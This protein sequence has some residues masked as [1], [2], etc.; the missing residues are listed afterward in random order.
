MQTDYR[1]Y[2]NVAGWLQIEVLRFT[3]LYA[4]YF[5]KDIDFDSLEIGVHHGKFIIGIE[6]ITP[7]QSRCLAIDLFEEQAKNVD[8][9]GRGNLD[10]FKQHV[11]DY[12]TNPSRVQAI[13]A[14]S[15][16]LDPRE[17]GLNKFGIVSID[18]GHT[19]R[20]T[21][22]D[23][24][25]G[26]R[27]MHPSGMVI[28]DDILNQ[29]WTGVVSGAVE[30][31][32]SDHS[33]RLVPFAIGCNKLFCCHFSIVN[34]VIQKFMDEKEQLHEIGLKPNKIGEFAGHSVISLHRT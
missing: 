33:N 14:D 18:G 3:S 22:S 21:F 4:D 6:N 31:F 23:L 27:I 15:L 28:L 29:D 34:K 32:G 9:S 11:Q 16:D 20:H 10:I 2:D 24:M 5:L 12:C 1:H 7:V 19:A 25:I 30:F 26:A 17:L 13:S 8:L